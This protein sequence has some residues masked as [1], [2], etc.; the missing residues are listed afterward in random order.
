MRMIFIAMLATAL[1]SSGASVG[2]A[3]DGHAGPA[4]VVA[5][6]RKAAALLAEGGAAGLEVLRDNRSEFTWKD[7][8]IFVV[9]CDADTVMANPAGSRA[10]TLEP[11]GN[12][13]LSSSDG[14]VLR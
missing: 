5:K 11:N 1:L 12:R 4:E 10:F 14:A 9:N 2:M 3:Q 7:T 8:Y 6:V 13:D